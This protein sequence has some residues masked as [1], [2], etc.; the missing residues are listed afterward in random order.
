MHYKEDFAGALEAYENAIWALDKCTALVG[1]S[2]PC[3]VYGGA[4]Q[5]AI[6]AGERETAMKHYGSFA[7]WVDYLDERVPDCAELEWNHEV[8]A[9]LRSEL[10]EPPPT[11]AI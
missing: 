10:G 11:D 5:A 4:A 8:M 3:A 2:Q 7:Q 9:W 6:M 1:V